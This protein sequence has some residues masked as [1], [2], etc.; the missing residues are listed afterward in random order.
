MELNYRLRSTGA[1]FIHDML[2][3][4]VAWF[5]AYWLRFN[6][7]VI[8]DFAINR[9]LEYFPYVVVIQT[10]FFQ[11]LGLYRGV[12]RFASI[13]DLVRMIKAVTGGVFAIAAALFLLSRLNGVPRSVLPLYGAI[14]ILL[15]CGPRFIYRSWKDNRKSARIGPRS[16]VIGAGMAGEMLVRDLLR[17]AKSDYVPIGFVDDDRSKLNR[18]IHGIR[19]LGSCNALP[20]LI[21]REQVAAILIA[22]PSA[23]DTQMRRIVEI[24]ESC[25]VPFLTLPSV[26][27][28]LSGRVTR[29][30][31]RDVSIEDLLGRDPIRLDWQPIRARL[32]KKTVLVTGGGGSIGSE[33]CGQ[34]SR[35]SIAKLVILEK[36]EFNLYKVEAELSGRH[37]DLALVALLGDVA[38]ESTVDNVVAK[39]RPDIIFHAAAYKHVP[40]LETQVREAVKNN[41]IGTKIVAEAAIRHQVSEFVLIST[42]K[43]VNPTNVMGSC[44]RAA[45]ILCQNY[46]QT[47][48]TRFITVRFGNVLDSAGSVVPLFRQQIRNG[49]PVTVTDPDITRFFM[50]IP[51]ACQLILEAAAVGEGGEI[52]VLDMGDPVKISYL[53]EQMI[54]LS[55]KRPDQDIKIE[56]IGLR[57][58][59]KMHEELFHQ[60]EKLVR[61]GHKKL[62]LARSR[63]YDRNQIQ[64]QISELQEA[65]RRFDDVSVLRL[66][67][68]LVPEYSKLEKPADN[69][70]YINEARRRSGLH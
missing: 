57:P 15:L 45:E 25:N 24:C 21:E 56:Y 64:R 42:D 30:G 68:E 13:P 18:E 39:I 40:L 43:A 51:E 20:D 28:V 41:I 22:I 52:F 47:G 17:E 44:K 70:V 3:I 26:R 55:G 1:V 34:I 4:P 6:L 7:D 69:L 59:E 16:I 58:G 53:A 35:L 33:L 5:G 32:E 36:S 27:D 14:L 31:L 12:W 63:E 19:V 10:L 37:P 8:P 66:L 50:T 11:A 29:D 46:N 23:N 48:K 62:F 49:G 38:D 65:C 60:K 67:K 2:M 9:A 61:T 54:R